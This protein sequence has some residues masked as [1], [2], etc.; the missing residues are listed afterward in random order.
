MNVANARIGGRFRTPRSTAPSACSPRSSRWGGV[1]AD[2]VQPGTRPEE[3]VE[4]S[5]AV[6]FLSGLGR[7]DRGAARRPLLATLLFG[8]FRI[9]ELLELRWRDVELASG[10]L[11]IRQSKTDA[12]RRDVKIRPVLRDELA[13]HRANSARD[14]LVFGTATGKPHSPS[15]V[16]VRVLAPAAAVVMAEMGHTDPE[17]ALSIYAAAMHRDEAETDGLQALVEGAHWTHLDP[18]P[19]DALEN[20]VFGD[21]PDN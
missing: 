11:R 8:G 10:W 19:A 12:G 17:L 18:N 13:T 2:R 15:N 21:H 20:D 5:Q 3:A 14:V 6:P 1:R 9:G 16:R 4:G 7:P